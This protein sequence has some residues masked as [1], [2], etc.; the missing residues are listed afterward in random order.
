MNKFVTFGIMMLL[1]IKMSLLHIIFK[2][3]TAHRG[4]HDVMITAVL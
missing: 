3:V 2:S 4:L 1:F